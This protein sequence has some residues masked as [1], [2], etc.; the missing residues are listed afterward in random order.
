MTDKA[1]EP[2]CKTCE[3]GKYIGLV[4]ERFMP[5]DNEGKYFWRVRQCPTCGGM[6]KEK[7]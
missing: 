7:E 3:G 4:K 1:K 2:V 5:S 6:G